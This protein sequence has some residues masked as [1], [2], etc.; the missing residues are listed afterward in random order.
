MDEKQYNAIK[1]ID[2]KKDQ[3]K[4]LLLVAGFT[5]MGL[6]MGYVIAILSPGPNYYG[7]VWTPMEFSLS[8]GFWMFL[9]GII[10][11]EAFHFG[12]KGVAKSK[13]D[14]WERDHSIKKENEEYVDPV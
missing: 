14:A 8:V 3:I 9:I 1:Q 11:G 13:T 12:L 5:I 2:W 7:Y 4:T 6:A 10:V